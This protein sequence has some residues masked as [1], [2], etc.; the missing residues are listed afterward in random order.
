[1]SHKTT[2]AST[3]RLLLFV[4]YYSGVSLLLQ[5]FLV[6]PAYMVSVGAILFLNGLL[7]Y[8]FYQVEDSNSSVN[9]TLG[10]NLLC[11]DV[12]SNTSIALMDIHREQKYISIE[13][14]GT[15]ES[16]AFY[17][18]YYIFSDNSTPAT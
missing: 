14:A 3:N 6:V 10:V 12:R 8:T 5:V 4:V 2:T 9:R 7:I 13:F 17:V 11:T 18:R 15:L 16:V 1:M